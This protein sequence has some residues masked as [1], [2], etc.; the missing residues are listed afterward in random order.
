VSR[1]SLSKPRRS[2]INPI[3]FPFS[4][5]HFR[6][7]IGS[8]V[9]EGEERLMSF[10]RRSFWSLGL[11]VLSLGASI[12]GCA[13]FDENGT[14]ANEHARG[15]APDDP[16]HSYPASYVLNH[17]SPAGED[18]RFFPDPKPNNAPI[19]PDNLTDGASVRLEDMPV[20]RVNPSAYRIDDLP[21]LPVAQPS[22]TGSNPTANRN[23][24]IGKLAKN[25]VS[26]VPPKNGE[27]S[28]VNPKI[29]QPKIDNPMNLAD[30][31]KPSASSE[32]QKSASTREEQNRSVQTAQKPVAANADQSASAVMDQHSLAI[33]E[34]PSLE[35]ASSDTE[36]KRRP[37]TI[38]DPKADDD[39]PMKR[40]SVVAKSTESA[41]ELIKK[42]QSY[43]HEQAKSDPER[44]GARAE[45]IDRLAA[46][47]DG[48]AKSVNDR[49]DRLSELIKTA[50]APLARSIAV[51]S[52]Q[53]SS[54]GA[55]NR[56]EAVESAAKDVRFRLRT[57]QF[58]EKIGGFG[59]YAPSASAVFKPGQ[60]V[61]VY[62]EPE[63]I[64]YQTD[65]DGFRSRIASRVEILSEGSNDP[66][67]S[68]D[69]GYVEDICRSK[70]RD[71]Y[72]N[73]RVSLP[74]SLAAGRYRLKV[75][76]V[77]LIGETDASTEIPFVVK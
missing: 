44:W 57:A 29:I 11:L 50:S 9:V 42:L 15:G 35:S 51:D 67:W 26:S 63:G 25:K 61:L 22:N 21:P 16:P 6:A 10:E 49:F 62:C 17:H 40:S 4:S 27:T 47:L 24:S 7:T 23:P 74:E 37:E 71:Y 77:D 18:S 55:R 59:V 66:V 76:Q 32:A 60:D 28:S 5:G 64:A 52:H 34:P 72:V 19:D 3:G 48:R 70:R 43:A 14:R 68:E 65:S 8:V 69:M 58:C 30:N 53:G 20:E 46:D 54:E 56:D 39:S 33:A 1:L 45:L 38:S 36:T 13:A 75:S 73:F 2:V 12:G 41:A 31:A